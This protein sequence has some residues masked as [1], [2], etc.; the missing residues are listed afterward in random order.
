VAR[1]KGRDKMKDLRPNADTDTYFMK[2]LLAEIPED[3]WGFLTEWHVF[4]PSLVFKLPKSSA[5]SES[6]S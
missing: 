4:L 2:I 6:C 1:E 3:P 5:G